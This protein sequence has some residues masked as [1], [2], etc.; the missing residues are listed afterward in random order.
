MAGFLVR[1]RDINTRWCG[2]IAYINTWEGWLYL[3]TVID[4]G[5]RKVVGWTAADHLAPISWSRPCATP[6]HS[7]APSPG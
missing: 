2:D 4:L 7:A 6:S 1:C 5:S 3:A